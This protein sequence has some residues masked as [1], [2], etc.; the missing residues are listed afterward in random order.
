MK[1]RHFYIPMIILGMAVPALAGTTDPEQI[2]SYSRL[3]N[4]WRLVSLLGGVGALGLLLYTRLGARFRDWTASIKP[5]FL[6]LWSFL[7]LVLVAE[8]L[9][10]LP[11][12][13]YRGFIAEH[14]Y[15]ISNQS[16]GQ[17]LWEDLLR[18]A[19]SVA[20][21]IVPVFGFYWL[22]ERAKRWWLWLTL[23]AVPVMIVSV[24]I[25]PIL[26]DPVFNDFTPLAAPP[27][28]TEIRALA[29][30][31]GIGDAD[32]FQIDGS[33]QSSRVNAYVT[34][35]LGSDRIVFYD[36][37]LDNFTTDEIVF[38][39][40][41]EMGHYTMH[42]LWQGIAVGLVVTLLGLWLMSLVLPRV[43]DRYGPRWGFDSLS[44]RASLPLVMVFV[45]VYMFVIQPLPN[46]ASRYMERQADEYAL[47]IS[48][49]SPEVALSAY[50]K[51][52]R[53]N[54]SDPDPHPLIHFWF[55]T[56]PTI[57]ERIERVGDVM[58]P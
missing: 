14:A 56:H 23:A 16:F 15:G 51:L 54:L 44:D 40:A 6:A 49:V 21:S 55:H 11:F 4:I 39:M 35:L 57:K 26:I 38:V 31:G 2:L 18:L 30:R 50:E 5:R 36:T 7:A 19:V 13:F 42:H 17:W 12:G 52:S 22:V 10:Y 9:L 27:L 3:V 29:E 41:H 46:A 25:A 24:L 34:G 8:Y 20:I 43:I 45:M 33:R 1:I 58:H 37:M 28:E 48:D 53:M 47:A 32:I